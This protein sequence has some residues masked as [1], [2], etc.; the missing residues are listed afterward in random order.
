L[1]L[2]R[3]RHMSP[4]LQR[5]QGQRE[6][7]R[8]EI[9]RLAGLTLL[10]FGADWCGYCRALRPSLTALLAEYPEVRHIRIEDGKG[11]PLGRSFQVKLWPT[12]VF[13]RDGHMVHRAVRPSAAQARAGFASLRE[14]NS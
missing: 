2:L 4:D 13:L 5:E 9:D 8:A 10:E 3:A 7:T 11:Q 1:P 14:S 12:L 6:P